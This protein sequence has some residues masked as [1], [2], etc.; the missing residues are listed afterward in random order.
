MATLTKA[1][2]PSVLRNPMT[3]GGVASSWMTVSPAMRFTRYGS[4]LQNVIVRLIHLRIGGS[5]SLT[6]KT[7][8]PFFLKKSSRSSYSLA[9]STVIVPSVTTVEHEPSTTLPHSS[10]RVARRRG[11]LNGVAQMVAI[12]HLPSGAGSCVDGRDGGAEPPQ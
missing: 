8:S 11:T 4:T 9:I 2:A 3:F 5:V 1:E 7:P 6:Q 10:R 12:S